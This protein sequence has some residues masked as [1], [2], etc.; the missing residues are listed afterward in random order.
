MPAQHVNLISAARREKRSCRKRARNW[1]A[2]VLVY[3]GLAASAAI[4]LRLS[5]DGAGRVAA[6]DLTQLQA[7]LGELNRV[8][9]VLRQE[10]AEAKASRQ[11]ALALTGAPDWSDLMLLVRGLCAGDGG[12]HEMRVEPVK[13]ASTQAVRPAEYS[14]YLSGTCAS[15]EQITQIVRRFENAGVFEDLKLL[16]SRREGSGAEGRVVFELSAVLRETPAKG[17]K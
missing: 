15:L 8:A 12:I 16:R 2:C 11:T 9:G 17:A 14:V 13:A 3:A 6:A 1:I 5:G 4:G 10:L 7:R